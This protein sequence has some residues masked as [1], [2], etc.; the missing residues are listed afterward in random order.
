MV[1][2]GRRKSGVSQKPL[3]ISV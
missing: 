2:V 3:C 1:K